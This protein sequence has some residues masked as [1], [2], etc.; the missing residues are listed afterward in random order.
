MHPMGLCP[1]ASA[2]ILLE[3]VLIEDVAES[4][5]LDAGAAA[6][7]PEADQSG[8]GNGQRPQRRAG[9]VDE[10]LEWCPRPWAAG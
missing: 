9:D 10:G 6:V 3:P 5:V 7:E 1:H 4:E 2:G 8:G